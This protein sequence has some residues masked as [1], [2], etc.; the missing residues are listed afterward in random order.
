MLSSRIYDFITVTFGQYKFTP[1]K[2][3]SSVCALILWIIFSYVDLS[4]AL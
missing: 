3:F 4:M 1:P 2:E